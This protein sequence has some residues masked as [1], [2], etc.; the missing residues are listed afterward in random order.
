M[1][2]STF[3]AFKILLAG[4]CLLSAFSDSLVEASSPQLTLINPR[5][6]QRGTTRELSFIG[7]R[8]TDAKEIFFYDKGVTAD[9]IEV[10]KANQLKVTVTVAADC[11]LGEHIAQVR[12]DSGISDFRSFWVGNLKEVAEVEPNSSFDEPQAIE[13]DRKMNDTHRAEEVGFGAVFV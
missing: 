12:C 9:K 4:L 6:V 10:V 8:L 2:R 3:S 7:N 13:I 11:R 5:G 1:S